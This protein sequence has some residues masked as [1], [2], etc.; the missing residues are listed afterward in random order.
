MVQFIQPENSRNLDYPGH[1]RRAIEEAK[2]SMCL[3]RRVGAVVVREPDDKEIGFDATGRGFYKYDAKEFNEL[4]F[5]F[6]K[7]VPAWGSMENVK[8]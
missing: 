2:R 1:I 6:R 8:K 4:S 7:H 5:A 3:H